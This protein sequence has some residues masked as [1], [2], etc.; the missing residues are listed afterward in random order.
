MSE[1]RR[2]AGLSEE[3]PL[4]SSSAPAVSYASGRPSP[5][6]RRLFKGSSG[7][8]S[9]APSL[10]ERRD[11]SPAPTPDDRDADDETGPLAR[12]DSSASTTTAP[13]LTHDAA[14][15]YFIP[16]PSASKS[17]HTSPHV[18]ATA[19]VTPPGPMRD[20]SYGSAWSWQSD[21]KPSIATR[22]VVPGFNG[23]GLAAPLIGLAKCPDTPGRFA[24]AGRT[25]AQRLPVGVALS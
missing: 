4:P 3:S 20:W 9:S 12:H 17:G 22:Y 7:L 14:Q 5:S 19:Y 8:G 11:S 15:G 23:A 25:S 18:S 21:H 10:L 2:L 24:V 1:A 13:A 6:N 16:R